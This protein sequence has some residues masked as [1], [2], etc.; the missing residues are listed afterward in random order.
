[1]AGLV[2]RIL[3]HSGNPLGASCNGTGS[4]PCPASVRA[5]YPRPGMGTPAR[6]QSF[7]SPTSDTPRWVAISRTGDVHRRLDPRE[8]ASTLLTYQRDRTQG[9]SVA[10]GEHACHFRRVCHTAVNAEFSASRETAVTS[11]AHETDISSRGDPGNYQ[12]FV[13]PQLNVCQR[14]A[15]QHLLL[16]KFFGLFQGRDLRIYGINLNLKI[17]FHPRLI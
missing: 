1:M 11:T 15:I 17:L 4:T 16:D 7:A 2:P 13:I 9:Q 10:L 8:A 5:Q 14:F 3:S 12:L 6:R